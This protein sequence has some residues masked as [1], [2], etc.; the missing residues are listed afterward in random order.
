M[1]KASYKKGEEFIRLRLVLVVIRVIPQLSTRLRL[2]NV[3]W[4]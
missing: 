1:L 2:K 4:D 3:C